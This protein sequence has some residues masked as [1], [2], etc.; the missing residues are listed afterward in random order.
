MAKVVGVLNLSHVPAIAGAIHNKKHDDPYWKPWFDGFEPVHNWVK[1]LN[2]TVVV[3]FHNDHGLNFFLDKLPTFAI[4]VAPKYDVAD[5]GWNINPFRTFD[6]HEELAWH[7]REELHKA[8]FDMVVCQEYLIDHS[9][10]VPLE[11]CWP[12]QTPSFKLVPINLNTIL[13]PTPTPTRCEKLGKAVNAAI[14]GFGS[15]ER[16][17]IMG[18]GGLS[19]QL[20]GKRAG[21]INKKFDIECMDHLVNDIAW[22]RQFSSEDIVEKAGTQGL[23]VLNWISARGAGPAS[24]KEAGRYMKI[25]VSNT[26]GSILC[27]EPS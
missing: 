3:M 23:E 11:L 14:G 7:I 8:E 10:T 21:F 2:P 9:V 15:D 1:K 26:A 22:F 13:F 27:L 16:V 12:G 20:E 5:E 6:G 18:T 25:P 24:M 4:G 19:H 17:L